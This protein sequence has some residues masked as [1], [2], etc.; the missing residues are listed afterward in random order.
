MVHSDVFHPTTTKS[1]GNSSNSSS[2]N[3]SGNNGTLGTGTL[4][5][6]SRHDAQRAVNELDNTTCKNPY[7][8]C[9]VHLELGFNHDSNT[10]A[11][12]ATTANTATTATTAIASNS[13]SRQ[14]KRVRGRY[15]D[16]DDDEHQSRSRSRSRDEQRAEQVVA[17]AKKE[18]VTTVP[19][20]A[21]EVETTKNK[22]N[23][24][25]LLSYADLRSVC[26]KQGLKSSGKK[27]KLL[28]RLH[29][30]LAAINE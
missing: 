6:E 30:N 14:R 9:I 15:D 24:Y 4:K 27:I 20:A 13:N 12:T 26:K 16:A 18:Q 28:A 11:T 1:N 10:T 29:T 2:R 8:E 21:A 7:E 23:N 25:H 5:Y 3:S 17:A 22:T 19:N